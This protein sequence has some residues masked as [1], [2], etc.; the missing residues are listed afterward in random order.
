MKKNM[1]W[2]LLGAIIMVSVMSNFSTSPHKGVIEAI[3]IGAIF[4][5]YFINRLQEAILEVFD[6]LTE[7]MDEEETDNI[8]N[9]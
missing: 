9:Q 2:F 6:V 3:L 5:A 8:E 7:D 1:G 4:I